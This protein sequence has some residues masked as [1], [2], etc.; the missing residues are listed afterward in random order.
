MIYVFKRNSLRVLFALVAAIFG[1]NCIVQFA[2]N[3]SLSLFQLFLL[4]FFF[5]AGTSFS[6]KLFSDLFCKLPGNFYKYNLKSC[7]TINNTKLTNGYKALGFK[8]KRM[9]GYGFFAQSRSSKKMNELLVQ[10]KKRYHLNYE[11]K[12]RLRFMSYYFHLWN[13]KRKKSKSDLHSKHFVKRHDIGKTFV[14][15]EDPESNFCIKTVDVRDAIVDQKLLGRSLQLDNKILNDSASIL[16]KEGD[17]YTF[18]P[19]RENGKVNG[20]QMNVLF[21][22]ESGEVIDSESIQRNFYSYT[23]IPK[24]NTLQEFCME[25]S[26]YHVKKA[27]SLLS[28]HFLG[29]ALSVQD[30]GAPVLNCKA[31]VKQSSSDFLITIEDFLNSPASDEKTAM[32]QYFIYID[33]L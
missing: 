3:D 22:T 33:S 12:C 9:N 5:C 27:G 20:L 13:Q 31:V 28:V 2:T 11:F 24:V 1:I 19:L 29:Y 17:F 15:C 18:R 4:L 10:Y 16:Q 23:K 30:V 6:L 7:L 21:L 32:L 14:L 25:Q 26:S 8:E